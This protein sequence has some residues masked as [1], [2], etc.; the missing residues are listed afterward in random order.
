MCKI[1]QIVGKVPTEKQFKKLHEEKKEV[2]FSTDFY[3]SVVA[4]IA[5]RGMPDSTGWIKMILD[6]KSIDGKKNAHKGIEAFIN[7]QQKKGV[8]FFEH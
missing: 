5:D 1:L 4:I 2:E 7:P 3:P 6:I 8:I